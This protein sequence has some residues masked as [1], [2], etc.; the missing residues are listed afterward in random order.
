VFVAVPVI[1]THGVGWA[2]LIVGEATATQL[3]CLRAAPEAL[4]LSTEIPYNLP[5]E[6]VVN[7]EQEIEASRAANV[8]LAS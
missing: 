3:Y 1:S 7:A 8:G 2:D 4:P 5:P 6:F